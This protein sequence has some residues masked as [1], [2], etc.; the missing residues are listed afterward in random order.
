MFKHVQTCCWIVDVYRTLQDYIH[1][2][3][4]FRSNLSRVHSLEFVR[5]TSS[6]WLTPSAW[7]HLPVDSIVYLFH[8]PDISW[9]PDVGTLPALPVFFRPCLLPQPLLCLHLPL[10]LWVSLAAFISFSSLFA[11]IHLNLSCFVR[12]CL[13]FSL[14]VFTCVACCL[15]NSLFQGMHVLVS[16][17]RGDIECR[18][19]RTRVQCTTERLKDTYWST[20]TYDY[21][22]LYTYTYQHVIYMVIY[23]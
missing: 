3:K 23:Q 2:F 13:S 5:P 12:F 17:T 8:T 18:W 11:C 14:S 20:C 1:C 15:L 4:K 21:N 9:L 22:W 6:H 19:R 7:W 16:C 10:Y